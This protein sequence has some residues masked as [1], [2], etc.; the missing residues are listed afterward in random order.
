M[1]REWDLENRIASGAKNNNP[2]KEES[3][4]V[5]CPPKNTAWNSKQGFNSPEE[6]PF[7][8]TSR[9]GKGFV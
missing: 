5:A 6:F 4:R 2:F 7:A 8:S 1:N 3:P 9:G